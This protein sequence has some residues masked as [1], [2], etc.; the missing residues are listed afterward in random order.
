MSSAAPKVVILGGGLTGIS[1]AIHLRRPWVLF[2]REEHL[3]G[4]AVTRE[5][6]GGLQTVKL[7]GPAIVTTLKLSSIYISYSATAAATGHF[8]LQREIGGR[9]RTVVHGHKVTRSRW[10][11]NACSA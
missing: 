7:K 5:V 1:A 3:G 6:D 10:S 11:R 4:L 2:E 9:L 8:T